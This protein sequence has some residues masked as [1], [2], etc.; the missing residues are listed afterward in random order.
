[1]LVVTTLHALSG[2]FSNTPVSF[3]FLALQF[4]RCCTVLGKGRCIG[5]FIS[6]VLSADGELQLSDSPHS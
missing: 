3:W 2:E 5:N 4:K 6:F 1:L